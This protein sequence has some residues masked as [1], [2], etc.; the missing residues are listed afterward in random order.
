MDSY[1]VPPPQS[2]WDYRYQVDPSYYYRGQQPPP[3]PPPPPPPQYGGYIQ[4]YAPIAHHHQ[5]VAA[6]PVTSK[7]DKRRQTMASRYVQLN[8]AFET[9]RDIH[10][11]QMLHTL[12]T[13]LT[14]LHTGANA[15]FQERLHDIEERRDYELVKLRLYEQYLIERAEGEYHKQVE[16]AHEE[17]EQMMQMVKERLM[18]RLEAQRKKLREDKALLD[19]ANDHSVFLSYDRGGPP[20][21]TDNNT[22]AGLAPGSPQNG[23]ASSD[24]RRRRRRQEMS[25]AATYDE[26]SALSG[27]GKSSQPKRARG[28]GG[29]RTGASD[30]SDR[31]VLE[32]VLF[33]KE[34]DVP[35]TRHTSR[36]YQGVPPLKP[37]EAME[38][39]ALIRSLIKS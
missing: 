5:P 30:G 31:D 7:R 20:A 23:G 1:Y 4:Q 16:Q 35:T 13:T 8:E 2:S 10:Y 33:A 21:S 34:R 19:I 39:I 9:D 36:S 15:E 26:L 32:G 12:Q 14:S 18:S 38:D 3:P 28:S 27:D 29:N 24:H 17:H 11:R 6:A 25:A 22:A 37:D